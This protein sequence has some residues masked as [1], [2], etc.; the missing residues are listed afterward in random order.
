MVKASAL[1]LS[2][3]IALIVSI[4]LGSLIYL[5]SF[6][7]TEQ[8]K[9]KRWDIL[10]QEIQS[11]TILSLSNYFPYTDKDSLILSPVTLT[12]SM[13]IGKRHWGFFDLV[14]L[15]SW[16]N[17]DSLH[18][19][20][21]AGV[22][23]K[24]ST[25]LYIVDEDR[26]IS[27]SGKTLLEGTA[28]LPKSG[29]R[30]AFVD[31]SY[32]EG[33]EEMVDGTIKESAMNLPAHEQDRIGEIKRF[34]KNASGSGYEPIS[35]DAV[36]KQSFFQPTKYYHLKAP[37]TLLQDSIKGNIVIIAD[38]A[39]TISSR[40]S[41]EDAIV[42]APYIKLE[43]DFSGK[44]QFFAL[45]SIRTG[46]GVKLHYP[47]VLALLTPDSSGGILQL[48][49]GDNNTVEGLILLHRAKV[50]DQ[51]DVLS[52]GKESKVHGDIVSFG[53]LKY[54][55]PIQ[56]SGAVYCY[57]FITQRPS[58]LYENYLINLTL[59]RQ[60]LHPY[61]VRPHFWLPDKSTK[62]AIVQWLK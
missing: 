32:Y 24:D 53:L 62:Q 45:D 30:P 6:Y 9:I 17:S 26:P 42:I 18:R 51:K 19:S 44:G 1:H 13:L 49:L 25:V 22:T 12:D 40:T 35:Y 47:S 8:Q 60:K 55:D 57:R 31:G 61:Y 14:T 3:V 27:I 29:I 43:D 56:V 28:F 4:L 50:G 20:F 39:I 37:E 41:W 33:I 48:S 2:L 5:H 38:S 52:V 59:E 58:S 15:H 34:Y 54:T 36:L 11:G 7:R 10:Q 23:L 21:F 46:K 16:R